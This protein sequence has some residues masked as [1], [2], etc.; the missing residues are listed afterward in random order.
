MHF[1][2]FHQL[3]EVKSFNW[4]G[5]A[6]VFIRQKVAGPQ[7]LIKMARFLALSVIQLAVK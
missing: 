6:R 3:C 1:N 4:S 5:K 2:F 7:Q